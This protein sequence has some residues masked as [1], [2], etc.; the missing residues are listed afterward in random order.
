MKEDEEG[1]CAPHTSLGGGKR[2]DG[3]F[4]S[5]EGCE[6]FSLFSFF[7]FLLWLVLYIL[8][9]FGVFFVFCFCFIGM[10]VCVCLSIVL[11]CFRDTVM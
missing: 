3:K 9:F 5:K 1:I 2:D 8:F 11:F 6:E 7:F 10:C 4:F